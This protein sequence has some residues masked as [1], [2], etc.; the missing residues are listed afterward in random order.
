M[1]IKN[2]N[3]KVSYSFRINPELLEDLKLYAKGSNSTVPEIINHLIT[4]KLDGVTLTNDYLENFKR[5][6]ITIPSLTE[7]YENTNFVES[8]EV[9]DLLNPFLK[10][11]TYEVKKIPNNLDIW[12]NTDNL[13]NNHGYTSHNF[14]KL[15]H[16]GIEVLLAPEL[17]TTDLLLNNDKTYRLMKLPFCLL[18]IHFGVTYNNDLEITLL[19]H[20][21]TVQK[22]KE[23]NNFTL[24]DRVNLIKIETE[25]II[26]N[27]SNNIPDTPD[28]NGNYYGKGTY[29]SNKEEMYKDYTSILKQRLEEYAKEVNTG[30]IITDKA[31]AIERLDDKPV[32]LE[33][34]EVIVT[35]KMVRELMEENQALQGKVN[36]LESKFNKLT[37]IIEKL[38]TIENDN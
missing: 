25:E 5:Q 23:T 16:E 37:E 14:P 35:D 29:W 30:N 3:K 17:I 22:I 28:E 27:V 24:L 11:S 32:T 19:T 33:N 15:L 10:G 20:R 8:L 4:E 13:V 6:L 36:E 18:Y 21:E 9:M 34:N 7:I 2:P 38:E 31:G 1:Y 26:R 12:D